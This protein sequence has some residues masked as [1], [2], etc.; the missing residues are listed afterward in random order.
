MSLTDKIKKYLLENPHLLRNKYAETAAM[1]NTNYE[2]IRGTARRLRKEIGDTQ[3]QKEK[4][5]INIEE[6]E[7]SLKLYVENSNRVKSIDD[8]IKHCKINLDEWEINK[9]DIGKPN[10]AIIKVFSLHQVQRN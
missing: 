6:D 9:Y 4:E 7:K 10:K 3:N 2:V 8:L 1:F 5:V